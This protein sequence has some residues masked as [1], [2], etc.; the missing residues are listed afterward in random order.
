LEKRPF[1][2][3]H[4]RVHLL[5]VHLSRLD[6]DAV[7]LVLT[8]SNARADGKLGVICSTSSLRQAL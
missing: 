4:Q 2:A 6:S 3:P 1:E 8:K 5:A 7:H